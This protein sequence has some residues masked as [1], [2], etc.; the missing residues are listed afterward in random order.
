[1]VIGFLAVVSVIIWQLQSGSLAI[2][3][4]NKEEPMSTPMTLAESNTVAPVDTTQATVVSGVDS[5][6]TVAPTNS[7]TTIAQKFS[8]ALTRIN[9]KEAKPRFFIIIGSFGSEEES[10]RFLEGLQMQF[11]QYY[12][13]APY[14]GSKNFRLAVGKYAS[15]KEV[16]SELER[17][18][19][20]YP[21]DLWILN[22]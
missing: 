5:T 18:K 17:A 13:I 16:S 1:V 8:G 11:P 3:E 19:S 7:G 15:W 12:L 4:V 6:A 10:V 14:E 2:P 22:Y 21:K 9:S 20:A